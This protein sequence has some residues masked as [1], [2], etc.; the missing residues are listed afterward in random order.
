MT[1]YAELQRKK[2][3]RQAIAGILGGVAGGIALGV[4]SYYGYK[5]Y[6]A[7][8]QGVDKQ[9]AQTTTGGTKGWAMSW[10]NHH[11]DYVNDPAGISIGL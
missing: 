4:G 2:R 1:T 3:K 6:K 11:Y 5:K 8:K 7:Y 9:R 10:D